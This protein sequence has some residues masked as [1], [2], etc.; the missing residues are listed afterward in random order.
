MLDMLWSPSFLF[1]L[2]RGVSVTPQHR[3]IFGE[4]MRNQRKKAGC[5]QEKLAEKADLHPTYISRV[6]NGATNI[7]L[8]TMIRIAK[9]LRIKVND[10]TRD[11]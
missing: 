2:L 4:A 7:S 1:V 6:E 5:S 9:S 3:R 11:I 10:L 8:D